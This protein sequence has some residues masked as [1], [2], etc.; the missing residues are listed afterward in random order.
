MI[1][2][3]DFDLWPWPSIQSKLGSRSTSMPW[4][5]EEYCDYGLTF[6]Q[7]KWLADNL[8]RNNMYTL[9]RKYNREGM[10]AYHLDMIPLWSACMET[11]RVFQLFH[12]IFPVVAPPGRV[13]SKIPPKFHQIS[14]KFR[15]TSKIPWNMKNSTE[16][17]EHSNTRMQSQM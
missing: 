5:L 9:T 8:D 14:L 15:Q 12:G 13:L 17:L 10:P 7:Y 2:M 16:P 3:F 4:H 1:F 6:R 11:N